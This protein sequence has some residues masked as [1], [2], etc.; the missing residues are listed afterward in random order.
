M[1]MLL[2]YGIRSS[3]AMASDRH[4][5]DDS[6]REKHLFLNLNVFD[7]HVVYQLGLEWVGFST[8]LWKWNMIFISAWS[9]SAGQEGSD[10]LSETGP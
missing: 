10:F 2:Y 8:P 4:V 5:P 3:N 6:V 1:G 7:L 9:Q